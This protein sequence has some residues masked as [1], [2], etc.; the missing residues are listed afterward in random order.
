MALSP[1]VQHT[2]EQARAIETREVSVALA[3]GAGCGKT[4]VLTQ[5]LLQELAP[6]PGRS[7]RERLSELV[8]ITFTEAA[9]RELRSRVRLA[10]FKAWLAASQEERP[11][12]Q[13]L[14]RQF[15]N[16][17]IS[18]IHAFCSN[19]IR[20]YA[21]ELGLDPMMV[22]LDAAA[23]RLLEDES[24]EDALRGLL[25]QRD[26]NLMELAT[27]WNIDGVRKRLGALL[28]E[29][30]SEKFHE[31]AAREPVEVVAQWRQ[32]YE[33]VIWP[34][35][36]AKL[37]ELAT[38]LRAPLL[39]HPAC[40]ADDK[41]ATLLGL[42]DD[43]IQGKW[44]EQAALEITT[45]ADARRKPFNKPRWGD[46]NLYAQFSAAL[47]QLRDELRA[48]T[49]I[50]FDGEETLRAAELGIRLARVAV[51]VAKV[52]ESRKVSQGALDF[53]DQLALAHR[54]LTADKFRPIRQEVSR[55]ISLLMVD[56]FQD[57]DR[58]QVE[59]VRALV[60]EV[61]ESNRLF[62]VGDEK[63]SIYRF[64]KAEPKVFHEL[65]EEVQQ[66]GRLPL[67]VN[68]RSQPA[69]L[70]FVNQ[71]FGQ[72]FGDSYQPLTPHHTQVTAEPCVELLWTEVADDPDTPA[73]GDDQPAESLGAKAARQAEARTI[74]ARLRQL[75]D[76]GEA[77]VRDENC[78]GGCRPARYGDVAILFRA[79][80]DVQFYEQALRDVGID[81]Y[82]VGG[83]A[84]YSQQEVFDILHLLRSVASECDEISLAGV[85]RSPFFSL[86]DESLLW[87]VAHG[88]GLASGL[89]ATE[90]PPT[91]TDPEEQARVVAARR[92][93]GE[94]RQQKDRLSVPEL[95]ELA[96]ER[97]GYDAALLAEFMGDR[98]LA[99]IQK[100]IEQ[101]RAA[102]ASGVGKVGEFVTQLSKFLSEQPKEALAITSPEA[103][104][105]V[106]LMTV[107]QSKGLEFPIVV[108]PD[109][110]RRQRQSSLV[111][112]FSPELGP[113]VKPDD[114][115]KTQPAGLELYQ[116]VE[117]EE[118]QA[119]STRLFYVA[120]TRAEDYLLLSGAVG[121]FEKLTG[122]IK[123]LSESFD[124]HTGAPVGVGSE[125]VRVT[126]AEEVPPPAQAKRQRHPPLLRS[127]E[128]AVQR[129]SRGEAAPQPQAGPVTL[130][131][132]WITRLSVTRLSGQIVATPDEATNEPLHST[133]PSEPRGQQSRGVDPIALGSVVHAVME[134][135]DLMRP[136]DVSR[137]CEIFA[138]QYDLLHA[139]QVAAV[140][141]KLIT[142]FLSSPRAESMRR[143]RWIKREVEFSLL[144][145]H[146]ANDPTDRTLRGYIDCLYEDE[147]G[148]LRIVDYKTNQATSETVSQAA[149]QYELQMLVYALAVER[150]LGRGPDE[151]VLSFLRPGI[152]FVA[153]WNSQA[154]QRA[155]EL[156]GQ[157]MEEFLSQPAAG[158]AVA[159]ETTL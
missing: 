56:E 29:Y 85:L 140:G 52:Y 103:A 145:P 143:A 20:R 61:A 9:A 79:L 119:E 144:L 68:F 96:F 88:G 89:F 152:E 108:V 30:R 55:R 120:C 156:I 22:V 35:R 1:L 137:W 3:A 60:G 104:N 94:L 21:F 151:M 100:L 141:E 148:V 147:Q 47:K 38:A 123:T 107:H 31:W 5:R 93:L 135:L 128:E 114:W 122:W 12:W 154:R 113:L 138:T 95:L 17:R 44:S 33:T 110:A 14:L 41:I 121:D 24:I 63:Q 133:W 53:D 134:R 59:I 40:G 54:L 115:S 10:A 159:L 97:T 50:N 78:E 73:S 42:L 101:A 131:P 102:A 155:L 112:V 146:A 83:H 136:D 126:M 87:L 124:L 153:P 77:I 109:L 51:V 19:L 36:L 15:D 71:L 39:E 130:D 149:K 74:A 127:L 57:T 48:S 65:R 76:S 106:R 67:S 7:A 81:Y 8:A 6:Q 92:I 105:V 99:N 27:E 118:A 23:A 80:G 11:Y 28:S 98:K 91:I 45:L 49:G 2:D 117:R 129:A 158:R 69:I 72:A 58:L 16:C 34:R 86:C 111:G 157:A 90:L 142:G 26:D 132:R 125:V 84:F 32:F 64:R 13:E 25:A 18:T 139:G 66:P 37:I 150:A 75:F 46:E 82:L 116:Q 70:R 62:F 43:L 4:F